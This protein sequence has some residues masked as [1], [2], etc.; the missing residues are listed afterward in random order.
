[1]FVAVPESTIKP[2]ILGK[3]LTSAVARGTGWKVAM[4][5]TPRRRC[6]PLVIG[7]GGREF[8]RLLDQSHDA[9]IS[10]TYVGATREGRNVTLR[11]KV[12]MK[13]AELVSEM[14]A[15]VRSGI[16]EG[17]DSQEDMG[18]EEDI[19]SVVGPLKEHLARFLIL[20]EYRLTPE[21]LRPILK[22]IC[23]FHNF[24][25]SLGPIPTDITRTVPVSLDVDGGVVLG[26]PPHVHVRDWLDGL[27]SDSVRKWLIT[28]AEPGAW[29]SDN[30]PQG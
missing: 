7:P 2:R 29:L 20:D 12:L 28:A 11:H 25:L 23:A 13:R 30:V 19:Q 8:G 24:E 9:T 14:T 21:W 26:L 22:F 3:A 5:A 1:M 6:V 10:T 4:A 16:S 15:W 27:T 17:S 18:I